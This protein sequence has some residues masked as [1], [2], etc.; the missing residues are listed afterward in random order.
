MVHDTSMH[1]CKVTEYHLDRSNT[2]QAWSHAISNCS[3]P[4][5]FCKL[6]LRACEKTLKEPYMIRHIHS[7][8][9][10]W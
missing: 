6:K 3:K 4:E 2:M 5:A 1:S 8:F 7:M 10:W 9:A